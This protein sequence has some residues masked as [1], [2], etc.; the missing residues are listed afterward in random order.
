MLSKHDRDI[1]DAAKAMD[2]GDVKPAVSLGIQ[3][4]GVV[5]FKN[6][7]TG[8]KTYYGRL[9]NLLTQET[10]PTLK[11]FK[12]AN[13]ATQHAHLVAKRFARFVQARKES[14]ESSNE[15]LT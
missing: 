15:T 2:E 13:V 14:T 12:G 8:E 6:F 3:G 1:L 9:L 11:K 7:A 10:R 4:A 5:R